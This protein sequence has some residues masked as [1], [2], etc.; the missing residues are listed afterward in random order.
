MTGADVSM[1][2]SSSLMRF[3]SLAGRHS[4]VSRQWIASFTVSGS[5][6]ERLVK[7][8]QKVSTV[9]RESVQPSESGMDVNSR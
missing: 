8:V 7:H 5:L 1:M 9:L 2:L 6:S 3:F 4:S